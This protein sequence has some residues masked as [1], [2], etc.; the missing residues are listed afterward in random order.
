MYTP[1]PRMGGADHDQGRG[2]Q[3][4]APVLPVQR[5][6]QWA[7]AA[8]SVALVLGV[9][10]WGYRLAVRDVS[11]VPVI[12]AIE[13][14]AR[15]APENPGGDL[16]A[17]VGLAVNEVAGSGLAAPG[18][19]RVVLAPDPTGLAQE[20]TP[21][22]ALR[23]LPDL[24]APGEA[25][26]GEGETPAAVAVPDNARAPRPDAPAAAL[27]ES[28]Q[29]ATAALPPE[30]LP[31]TAED[32]AEDEVGAEAA[33][34]PEGTAISPD[35]PG[36]A[37]SPRPAARPDRDLEAEAA[38]LAVARALGGGAAPS[39]QATVVELDPKNVPKGTRVVQ[40]GAFDSP[41]VARAEW[42][43]VAVRFEALMA[44]KKRIVQE[45]AS[46]GRSFWRLRVEG[47]ESVEAARQFCA[48]LV[49][50]G[51]NCIPTVIK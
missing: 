14:P 49:A 18:P 1:D 28:P 15:I 35:I 39:A 10:I 2:R 4:P 37:R 21:M 40:L 46:G 7:G 51:T 30:P 26:E 50:E 25:P 16:A 36:L 38:A 41:E 47:F 8:T 22:A 13:G 5:W 11:G 29:A 34:A 9:V 20:D 43:R 19:D 6:V 12:R 23:P 24:A 32:A 44:G 31:E 17:H 42:D 3:S 45:A 27:P 33:P 48:A